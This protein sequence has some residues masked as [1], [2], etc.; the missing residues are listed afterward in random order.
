MNSIQKRLLRRAVATQLVRR[1]YDAA[2]GVADN[3]LALPSHVQERHQRFTNAVRDLIAS[4]RP[5]AFHVLGSSRQHVGRALA[6][7]S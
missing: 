4:K 1:R 6:L 2:S 7:W 5:G 3:P